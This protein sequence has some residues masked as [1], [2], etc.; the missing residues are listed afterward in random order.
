[1]ATCEI[2]GQH[3]EATDLCVQM[4]SLRSYRYS[5][6]G[7][8]L[9]AIVLL[10][11][12]ALSYRTVRSFQG[13]SAALL[14]AQ[15]L[16]TQFTEVGVHLKDLQ[17]NTRNFLTTGDERLITARQENIADYQR[18]MSRS[19]QA[20]ANDPDLRQPFERVEELVRQLLAQY[21]DYIALRRTGGLAAVTARVADGEAKRV[22]D[23]MRVAS[24][25]LQA[26]FG[27][28]IEAPLATV[29]SDTTFTL[30]MLGAGLALDVLLVIAVVVMLR[31][32]FRAREA[33][34]AAL[35]RQAA[36]IQDLYDHAPCGYH[37]LDTDGVFVAINATELSWLGY[38]REEVV[39]RMRLADVLTV[40]S[41]NAMQAALATVKAGGEVRDVEVEVRRKD[42]RTFP[43]SINSGPIRD[44]EGRFVATRTMLFD[45]TERK[46]VE[47][48]TEQ[49]R[50]YAESIV[51]TMREPLVILTHDLRVNSASRVF[52]ERFQIPA[53]EAI[54]RPFAELN[55]G[56]WAIPALLEVLTSVVP[57]HAEVRDFEV[58]RDFPPLGHRIMLLNARKLHRVGNGTMMMLLAIEDIT[59]R[60]QAEARVHELNA[61]LRSRTGE[62][63]IA[64]RELEAFSYSVSHDLRAPLR[65]IDYFA[66]S[67]QKHLSA[68]QLDPKA[69]RHLNT[70]SSSARNM[71]Q[72]I[73]D[74]LG[75]AR[76][77][78][79][80]L[81]RSRVKLDELVEETRQGLVTEIN[82]R[83]IA[84]A[85]SPLP[86]VEGDPALLRQVFMN[87]L[88]NA[89]KYTR[90]QAEARIEIA[91]QATTADEVVVRVRDN[92]AGFDM[93]Y[94]E[95]LFGVFQR[96]HSGQEFEGTGVGLANVRRILERHGGR[97]WAEAEV[98]R[99]ATFYFTLPVMPAAGAS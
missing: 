50:A 88:S 5:Q 8:L 44:A 71:G 25:E 22:S 59:E 11:I 73:D 6:I 87:L 41:R 33:A 99:G 35:R 30:R 66:S 63:E 62:L 79:T 48:V 95:K 40:E 61:V 76:I 7:I 13:A 78:R 24:N 55:A 93:K 34:A 77:A 51:D 39:G 3:R 92:G 54:G 9:A 42:G 18:V 81:R 29:R 26:N 27:R 4:G 52:C 21:E 97:I 16:R 15:E 23:E 89:V 96:L 28:K 68:T 69:Q 19:R 57:Q 80:E 37:S 31:R 58:A 70:I 60:K 94:A 98:D 20:V 45:L 47:Q 82:G 38:T 56:V 90:R 14:H 84:W 83:S 67:L 53:A 36:E 1:M 65:H 12:F 17:N 86:M 43:A 75:F 64:N 72:L 85:V 74:L 32:D 46:R 91:A 49:A 2:A 10:G